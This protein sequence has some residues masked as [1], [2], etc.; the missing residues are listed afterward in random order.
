MGYLRRE[1]ALTLLKELKATFESVQCT[2]WVLLR[3]EKKAGFWQL[4]IQWTPD[5]DEKLKLQPLIVKHNLEVF[6]ENGY[7]TFIRSK[8]GKF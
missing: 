7:A 8:L 1:E 5:E 3:N 2:T 6:F 4:S